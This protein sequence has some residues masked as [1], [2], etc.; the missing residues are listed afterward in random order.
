M[1]T[2]FTVHGTNSTGPE[3]G[4]QWWQRGSDFEKD[5]RELVEADDGALEFKPVVWDGKNSEASRRRAG[6]ALL[7]MTRQLETRGRSY[8]LIGHSHGGSV[9]A[10]ALVEGTKRSADLA[11]LSRWITVGTP[12]IHTR[13]KRLLFERLGSFGRAI[14]TSAIVAFISSAVLVTVFYHRMIMQ[15]PM[16]AITNSLNLLLILVALAL[17]NY[18]VHRAFKRRLA[19][20][21]GRALA[22]HWL[23][24]NH[25][26]DEAI[27]GLKS[28]ATIGWPIFNKDIAFDP[29]LL[30]TAVVLPLVGVVPFIVMGSNQQIDDIFYQLTSHLSGVRMW[31]ERYLDSLQAALPAQVI[32]HIRML[33]ASTQIAVVPFAI[34]LILFPLARRFSISISAWLSRRLNR[35]SWHSIRQSAFGSDLRAEFA[36]GSAERPDWLED[37]CRDLPPDL[38][39]ELSRH[40]D[41]AAATSLAKLRNAIGELAFSMGQQAK[42]DLVSQYITWD[43]LIHTAY[44]KVPIFRKFICYAIA[45]S[46]GFRPSA[47]LRA[48]PD[49]DKL[50]QWLTTVA[51]Q[52][53][54]VPAAALHSA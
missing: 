34:S 12:F 23:A 1:A 31:L 16:V 25:R 18:L 41:E 35:S 21:K 52:A 15:G 48:D 38:Q 39:A 22:T 46:P 50:E 20:N 27:G 47:K 17:F 13:L 11:H 42:T 54:A 3:E 6:T 26:S 8:L 9:I 40:A 19:T 45:H 49:Y 14:Y 53:H 29:L 36:V 51:G 24:L 32:W 7:G 5:V 33:L 30:I 10:H 4:P 28:V 2:I 44:F 43:E 37:G